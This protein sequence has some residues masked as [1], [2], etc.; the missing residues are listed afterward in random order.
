MFSLLLSS[1]D[2]GEVDYWTAQIAHFRRLLDMHSLGFDTTVLAA[3]RMELLSNV[4]KG[5]EVEINCELVPRQKDTPEI[6]GF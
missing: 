6:F 4:N 2:D 5:P 1:V 3:T